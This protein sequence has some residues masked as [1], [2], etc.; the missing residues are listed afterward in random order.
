M[1]R[2]WQVKIEQKYYPGRG[3]VSTNSQYHR[4]VPWEADLEMEIS[5]QEFFFFFPGMPW[6]LQLWKGERGIRTLQREKL[7]C[8]SAPTKSSGSPKGRE[9][10]RDVLSWGKGAGTL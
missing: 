4:L 2:V 3:H 8:D 7:S 10:I 6:D 9:L 5:V 1:H